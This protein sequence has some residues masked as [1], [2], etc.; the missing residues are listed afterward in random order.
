MNPAFYA[1]QTN[2]QSLNKYQ[3]SFNNPLRYVDPNG[4]DPEDPQ[5]KEIRVSLRH[6]IQKSSWLS[7][8]LSSLDG[9][10]RR[11]NTSS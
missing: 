6:Y 7:R 3:Y 1:D 10:R 8:L 11:M 2:P 5:E 4:H 9:R